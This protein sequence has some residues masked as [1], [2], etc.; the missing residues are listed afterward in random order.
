MRNFMFKITNDITITEANSY[1]GPKENYR[2]IR[3]TGS[4]Q[5]IDNV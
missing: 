5:L 2:L 3:Y 4:R 1:Q